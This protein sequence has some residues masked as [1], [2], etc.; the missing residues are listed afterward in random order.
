MVWLVGQGLGRRSARAP[1]LKA[2]GKKVYG[3][4]GMAP[5]CKTVCISY[6]SPTKH[7]DHTVTSY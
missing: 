3:T 1:V 5:E 6:E 2:F 4:F 7:F